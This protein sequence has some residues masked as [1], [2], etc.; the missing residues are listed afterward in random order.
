MKA[1][2]MNSEGWIDMPARKSQ[3]REPLISCADEEHRDHHDEAD[4]RA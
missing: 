1:G 4:E 2:F 3:R